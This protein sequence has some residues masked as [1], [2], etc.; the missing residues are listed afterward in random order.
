MKCPSCHGSG[1]VRD[2]RIAVSN[3]IGKLRSEDFHGNE[4]LFKRTCGVLRDLKRKTVPAA[5]QTVGGKPVTHT[6]KTIHI[7][8]RQ[9]RVD[10]SCG[11]ASAVRGQE[12]GATNEFHEHAPEAA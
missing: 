8:P 3:S 1:D 7:G 6:P 10:C 5:P 2:V 11:W 9:W 12:R 4:D